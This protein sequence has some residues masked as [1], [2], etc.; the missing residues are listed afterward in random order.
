MA[1]GCKCALHCM[2]HGTFSIKSLSGRC[3]SGSSVERASDDWVA[4][5]PCELRRRTRSSPSLSLLYRS[6][7]SPSASPSASGCGLRPCSALSSSSSSSSLAPR[8]PRLWRLACCPPA[9]E[10][11]AALPPLLATADCESLTD[12]AGA[13]LPRRSRRPR[14]H[15]REDS[16]APFDRL[17]WDL[18][19]RMYARTYSGSALGG[20]A[21]SIFSMRD[22]AKVNRVT[23]CSCRRMHGEGACERTRE[24]ARAVDVQG[25]MC[26]CVCWGGGEGGSGA[27]TYPGTC[28]LPPSLFLL[29]NATPPALLL[30]KCER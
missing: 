27:R 20:S 26:V 19:A 18:S 9:G 2:A 5:L 6:S 21:V 4:V 3:A 13:S 23:S 7:A 16:A 10:A 30:Q 29:T 15:R 8:S 24:C 14:R 17:A 28:S 12:A 1:E 25:R 11:P 22:R